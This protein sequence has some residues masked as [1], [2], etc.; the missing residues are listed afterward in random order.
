MIVTRLALH[1]KNVRNAIGALDGVSGL[2]NTIIAMLVESGV[3][4]A[5]SFVLLV[6]PWA[7]RSIVQYITLQILPEIQ[8]RTV[9][10]L[11]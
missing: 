1:T 3:L 5:F 11:F 2:Y 4:Y 10:Q 8:V 7:S 9:F 6:G